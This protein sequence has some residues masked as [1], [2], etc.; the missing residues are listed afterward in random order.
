MQDGR[1]FHILILFSPASRMDLFCCDGCAVVSSCS[2]CRRRKDIL[3]CHCCRACGSWL[4]SWIWL[5]APL[6]G[7]VGQG[8]RA[9][10]VFFFVFSRGVMRGPDFLIAKHEKQNISDIGVHVSSNVA[11]LILT[12]NYQS[13]VRS[14]PSRFLEDQWVPTSSVTSTFWPTTW[15]WRLLPADPLKIRGLDVR[16]GHWVNG[17]YVDKWYY[18]YRYR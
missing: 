2:G 16:K 10:N 13:S 8:R 14:I 5:Q 15:S 4:S 6:A 7:A 11:M 17:Q 18:V 3:G 12:Q 1:F 9:W